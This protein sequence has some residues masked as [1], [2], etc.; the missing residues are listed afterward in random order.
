ML[1]NV[2]YPLNQPPHTSS[3]REAIIANILFGKILFKTPPSP[4]PIYYK[5]ISYDPEIQ[6]VAECMGT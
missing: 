3:D 5:S 4:I 1:V 6:K 2:K